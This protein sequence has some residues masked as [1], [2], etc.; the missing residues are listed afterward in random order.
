MELRCCSFD[1]LHK[2]ISD[3]DV[4]IVMFGAGTIGLVSVPEILKNYGLQNYVDCYIDND[5]KKWGNKLSSCGMEF[6]VRSPE[7]LKSCP[8][9]TLILL[10]IS[11]F[12]EVIEQ[13]ENMESTKHMT[14]YIMPMM[15]I[16]NFCSD[17]SKGKAQ[18][19]DKPVIPRKLHYMWLGGNPIPDNLKKCMESWNK[20]CPGYEIIEWNENN[21]NIAKN[22]Y[23][24]QAYEAKAYGFVPD[25]ARLDILYNEGGFY[26]D[27]D[28]EI[29]RNIDDLRYQE[30]F[31]GVEK[32]QVINFGGLSGAMKGNPMIRAFLDAR[33][34]ILFCDDNGI[35]NR[36]TCGFYDTKVA[37]R[38]G[39]M[40]SGETQTIN[41]MN[42][43]AY[44]YFHPYDYMSRTVNETEHT[45]SIHWFNGGWLDGKMKKANDNTQK[46]YEDIYQKAVM[47][48]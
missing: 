27:T 5:S 32:W 29:K 43:Y 15:L 6:E 37:L 40:I 12:S 13:L 30:A 46:K 28:V 34:N 11:R 22:S 24:K 2:V 4:N 41:G 42:V 9:E 20:Y 10:N 18:L 21:Y 39:Y 16:H 45:Y 17:V 19:K 44:D 23:M 47:R 3:R 7:Y 48:Q 36:N 25:Y 14:C 8:D 26:L 35:L 31:C 38:Y 33:E 1:E